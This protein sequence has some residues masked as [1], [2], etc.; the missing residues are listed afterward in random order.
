MGIV[1]RAVDER[2]GQDVA[3]KVLDW[4]I[5][6]VRAQREAQVLA[7]TEHRSIVRYIADGITPDGRMFVAMEWVEGETA[8]DHIASAGFTVAEAVAIARQVADALATAHAGG[9]VH[10]DVKPANVLLVGGDVDEVRLI[11]FGV[12]RVAAASS[13]TR[14]G[15]TMGTPGYM[16]PEQARGD[17]SIDARADQFALGTVLYEMVSGRFAFDGG[18]T[19]PWRTRSSRSSSVPAPPSGRGDAAKSCRPVS[20]S[21]RITPAA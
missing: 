8:A 14:T 12:A 3:V 7:A 15:M 6:P 16:A 9:I 1:F 18:V 5:D 13:L 19:A 2:S 21:H 10:R 11:D 4:E 17:S 20:S